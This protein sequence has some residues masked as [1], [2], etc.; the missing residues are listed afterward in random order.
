VDDHLLVLERRVE[1]RND[2]D[3][4]AGRVGLPLGARNRERLG[5][6]AVLA[7]FAKGA[8]LELFGRRRRRGMDVLRSG[9]FRAL[10]RND[11]DPAGNGI[12]PEAR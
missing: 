8:L 10:W 9:P 2:A 7:P 1:V 12:R 11:D 5:R 3:E 4:P 6:G